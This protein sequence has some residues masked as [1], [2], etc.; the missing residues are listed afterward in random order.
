MNHRKISILIIGVAMILLSSINVS[1]EFGTDIRVND[2]AGDEGQMIGPEKTA[3]VM[4]DNI[5]Y[6]VC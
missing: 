5:V 2:D 4:K 1:A 6:A 3:V